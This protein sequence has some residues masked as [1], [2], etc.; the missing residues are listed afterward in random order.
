MIFDAM[1]N[2]HETT[3]APVDECDSSWP[4]ILRALHQLPDHTWVDIIESNTLSKC[5]VPMHRDGSTR[6]W[7]RIPLRIPH[8]DLCLE[9]DTDFW[10]EGLTVAADHYVV[11]FHNTKVQHL[12]SRPTWPWVSPQSPNY[13]ILL[14]RRLAYG[15]CG[16][17]GNVGVNVYAD[18]GLETFEGAQG[19]VQLEVLC[20]K[21][22]RLRGGRSGRYCICGPSDQIC[23][24]AALEALWVPKDELPNMVLL[25]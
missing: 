6:L 11:A 15:R 19:W 4:P 25:T 7:V 22:T 21:T 8:V 13:G 24:Y 14:Q 1:P 23:K 20:Q 3:D 12:V 5:S 17:E 9:S 10:F 16:H 18:G 2:P